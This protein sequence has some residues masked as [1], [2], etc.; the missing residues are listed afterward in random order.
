MFGDD[1][2]DSCSS[3]ADTETSSLANEAIGCPPAR[4][5]E[6]GELEDK[7][8]TELPPGEQV[9][10]CCGCAVELGACLGRPSMAPRSA[11]AKV[12]SS[13]STACSRAPV[14]DT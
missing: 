2:D 4:D 8:E 14:V 10:R 11:G 13:R 1:D 12:Y 3:D 5:E 9:S 6:V 7:L